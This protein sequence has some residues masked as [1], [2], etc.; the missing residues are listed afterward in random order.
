MRFWTLFIIICFSEVCKGQTNTSTPREDS[1]ICII[2]GYDSIIY[3]A[4]GKDHIQEAKRGKIDDIVFMDRLF[5]TVKERKSLVVLKPG[6]GGDM[7]G[8]FESVVTQMNVHD[9]SRRAIDSINI[10]EE[11]AFG[12]TTP[13]MIKASMRGDTTALR[14]NLPR[15]EDHVKDP[16]PG[17]PK[18][19]QVVIILAGDDSIYAYKGGDIKTIRQYTY[20]ELRETLKK[21]SKDAKFSVLIKPTDNCTYKNTVNMLD[22]MTLAGVKHYELVEITKEEA[23][24]VKGLH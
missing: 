3:Y 13:P 11:K 20:A 2:P 22:E 17:Y 10:E 23:E 7:M 15:D 21:S 6:D 14:L 24:C 5:L 18:Q 19:S 8:T 12:W 1:I 4:G 9:A 16:L